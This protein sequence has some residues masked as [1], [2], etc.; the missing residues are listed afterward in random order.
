MGS[1]GGIECYSRWEPGR[2]G[3]ATPGLLLAQ[4]FKSITCFG[5][6]FHMKGALA[7]MADDVFGVWLSFRSTQDI[8][9]RYIKGGAGFA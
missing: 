4:S 2:T 5:H 9:G 7:V 1:H 8:S 3:M 6:A